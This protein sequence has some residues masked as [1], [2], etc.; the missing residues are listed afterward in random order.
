MAVVPPSPTEGVVAKTTPHV[1]MSRPRSSVLFAL[2]TSPP[3]SGIGCRN[4]RSWG[5]VRTSIPEL[6]NVLR[7]ALARVANL[8][9]VSPAES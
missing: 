9:T 4:H 2:S 5:G 1:P 3:V 7:E 8:D 6:D